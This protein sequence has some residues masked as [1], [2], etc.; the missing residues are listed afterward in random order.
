MKAL[1]LIFNLTVLS[2]SLAATASSFAVEEADGKSLSKTKDCAVATKSM[3]E[4]IQG[5]PDQ[6]AKI[7]E[8]SISKSKDCACELLTAAIH[9]GDGGSASVKQLVVL[10]LK[11]AEEQASAIAECAV[12]AAPT[13][14]EAIRKAFA[15]VQPKPRPVTK[16]PPSDKPKIGAM[17]KKLVPGW[18]KKPESKSKSKSDPPS[19]TKGA[20]TSKSALRNRPS[21][22]EVTQDEQQAF[23]DEGGIAGA[24][25]LHQFEFDYLWPE[26]QTSG[27]SRQSTNTLQWSSYVE[28][29]FDSNVN[30]APGNSAVDSYFVGGGI[31]T[32]YALVAEG[33]RFDVRARFG[34]RYDENAP[35]GMGDV[36]YRG[37]LLA[38]LE[39]QISEQLKV[40]NQVSVSYDAEPDFLLGETTGFR[41]DQYIFAYNR[42]AFGYRWTKYF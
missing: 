36:I 12:I 6:L 3:L 18:K 23:G 42:L 39:H 9:A 14:L 37:R 26:L 33:S 15:E 31:G 8:H 16:K 24:G 2:V 29:G 11:H 13:Q 35:M 19:M 32:Y 7:F 22:K 1:R 40:S 20:V 25:S 28:N 10:A 41:S 38:N 5:D 30:T 4:A 21:G 34:V 27:D 17:I